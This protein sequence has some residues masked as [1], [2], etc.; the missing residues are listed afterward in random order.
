MSD[1]E[2]DLR[3]L[4]D[5]IAPPSATANVMARVRALD[6]ASMAASEPRAQPAA[7]ALTTDRQALAVAAGV[8]AGLVAYVPRLLDGS[9]MEHLFSPRIGGWLDGA[10]AL[11]HQGSVALLLAAGLACYVIGIASPHPDSR[12]AGG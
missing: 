2:A 8:A 11:P 5:P 12:G 7:P 3:N 1:W 9:L 4:S 10:A 6:H